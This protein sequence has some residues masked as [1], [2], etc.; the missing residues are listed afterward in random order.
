MVKDCREKRTLP[1]KSRVFG[2]YWI[3]NQAIADEETIFDPRT[4][5][6]VLKILLV[7]KSWSRSIEDKNDCLILNFY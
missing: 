1:L 2:C 3:K 7:E 6:K 5:C 4:Q